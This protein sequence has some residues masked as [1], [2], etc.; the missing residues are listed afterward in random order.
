MQLKPKPFWLRWFTGAGTWVTLAPTIYHPDS[1]PPLLFPGLVAH[2]T[3]HIWQQEA[4]G[5]WRWLWR[6]F[7]NR[8][9]RLAVEAEGIAAEVVIASPYDRER[10]IAAYSGLLAGRMYFWAARTPQDA[11]GAI[12]RAMAARITPVL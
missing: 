5:K 3:V 11:R 1:M 2:E 10:L 8:A 12:T 4:T 6:W 9:F 7:T